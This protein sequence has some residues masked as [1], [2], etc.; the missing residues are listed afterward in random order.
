MFESYLNR[1]K[2]YGKTNGQVHKT[3][4]DYIMNDTWWDDIQSRVG[5]LYDYYHDSESEKLEDLDPTT[6][7]LKQPVDIK[8]IVTQHPTL[9][10]S[11]IEYYIMFRPGQERVIDYY[12]KSTCNAGGDYPVGM[13]I[14]IPDQDEIYNRWLIVGIDDGSNQF[15]RYRVMR[16]NYYLHWCWNQ[17]L[18]DMCVVLRYRNS[19]NSGVWSDYM[20]TVVQNQN[21]LMFPHNDIT[22]HLYYNERFIIDSRANTKGLE[23]YLTWETSKVESMFPSGIIQLTLAQALF[24]P[25]TDKFDPENGYLYANYD[26][27]YKQSNEGETDDGRYSAIEFNG[28]HAVRVAGTGLNIKL[29]FYHKDGT[30]YDDINVGSPNIRDIWTVTIYNKDNSIYDEAIIPVE[31]IIS[32]IDDSV[33]HVNVHIDEDIQTLDGSIIKGYTLIGKYMIIHGHAWTDIIDSEAK[34]DIRSL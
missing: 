20:T 4:A 21:L 17:K 23:S 1:V 31:S 32:K 3:E 11:Q 18:Y 14:D 34:I 24:N 16:C 15:I 10:N 27:A 2:T 12:E 26:V 13:Y 8:F 33:T 19:Y 25:Q 6:D 9:S 30:A 29:A 5:Y 7:H 28:P 22:Q